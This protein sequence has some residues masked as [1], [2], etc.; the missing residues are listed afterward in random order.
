VLFPV[1]FIGTYIALA[2]NLSPWLALMGPSAGGD[3]DKLRKRAIV[4]AHKRV[5]READELSGQRKFNAGHHLLRGRL[6]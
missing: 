4:G 6:G 5:R 2:W 3:A 1:V